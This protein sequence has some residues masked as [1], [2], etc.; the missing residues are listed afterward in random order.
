M[1]YLPPILMVEPKKI[2]C[3]PKTIKQNIFRVDKK[4]FN[5]EFGN[6][7]L[8]LAKVQGGY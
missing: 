8:K 7:F 2:A 5:S 1:Y 6:C 4:K 3:Q